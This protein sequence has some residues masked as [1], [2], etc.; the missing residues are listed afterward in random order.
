MAQQA[1]PRARRKALE[2]LS[3]ALSTDP[4]VRALARCRKELA[5]HPNDPELL[6]L[7]GVAC[8]RLAEIRPAESDTLL[9]QGIAYFQK[10]AAAAPQRIDLVLSL[11]HALRERR[12]FRAARSVFE[13]AVRRTQNDP[14]VLM[15]AAQALA[16]MGY[17][18]AAE[19][20]FEAAGRHKDAQNAPLAHEALLAWT[21]LLAGGPRHEESLRIAAQ[22]VERFPQSPVAH[23]KYGRRL[24]EAGQ[25]EAARKAHE[26]ALSLDPQCVDAVTGLSLIARG[27]HAAPLQAALS[28]LVVDTALP[29]PFRAAAHFALGKASQE[30]GE[31]MAAFDH[32][33]AGNRLTWESLG[34]DPAHHQ[35]LYDRYLAFFDSAFLASRQGL[36]AVTNAPIF[37][38]GLPRSGTTLVEQILARHPLID[39]IGESRE[40]GHAIGHL[41]EAEA[42]AGPYPEALAA[43]PREAWA[44]L[45]ESYVETAWPTA[46]RAPEARHFVDK[47]PL[48]AERLPV[49]ATAFPHAKII[50]CVRDPRDVA[51]SL[52][53]NH[54]GTRQAFSYDL[55]ALGQFI[56]QFRAMMAAW[57]ERLTGKIINVS[58]ETLV[59]NPDQAIR[60]LTA[61]LDLPWD[62]R[63]VQTGDNAVVKTA[64]VWQARQPIHTGSVGRWK[65]FEAQLAPLLA[66][67]SAP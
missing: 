43:L 38:V 33:Q 64:S 39:G 55:T 30:Q 14:Q 66:V 9:D 46:H 29:V 67:L 3:K 6:N 57:Q 4:P 18:A 35:A 27:E 42:D 65:Q 54:F 45:A 24:A 11:G 59:T 37:V 25:L 15:I 50:Y 36:G 8:C 48:N 21:E 26:T 32:W 31:P 2:K 41:L 13:Q 1:S 40:L 20:Y 22:A 53:Q 63:M 10:A 5:A 23:A 12:R 17:G 19:P 61:A 34:Y 58:Y 7:T 62:D 28:P 16:D 56:N 49:I 44:A 60:Q 51:L 47:M 52:F